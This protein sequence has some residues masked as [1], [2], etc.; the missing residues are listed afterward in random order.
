MNNILDNIKA[1]RQKKGYGQE[2]MAEQLQM[3]QA[4][5]ALWE[6]GSRDLS[7]NNLL[8]IARVLEYSVIDI[9]TYPIKYID[10]T[11]LPTEQ[12]KV[13]VTFEVDP[14]QRDYL[15]HLVLGDNDRESMIS[16]GR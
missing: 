13:S 2:Y 14:R 15:L 12:E 9:I 7:Y 3:T 5:Y 4:G 8:R 16:K 10:P 6:K 11:T 1:I